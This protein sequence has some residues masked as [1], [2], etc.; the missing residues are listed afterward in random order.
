M[1]ETELA[2]I[3]S[4]L[5]IVLP[6]E[7]RQFMLP[8][9]IPA[10]AGNT[11]SELWD[12]ANALIELNLELRKGESLTRPWPTHTFA[13]GRDDGGSVSAFDLRTSGSTVYWA[14]RGHLEDEGN[15]GSGELFKEWVSEVIESLNVR[16]V[17]YGVSPD[18][19]PK[20]RQQIEATTNAAHSRAFGRFLGCMI[21]V[22]AIFWGAVKWLAFALR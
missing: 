6:S 22:A 18:S 20:E 2:Q 8:F 17:E 4:E 15:R 12:D 10:F 19:S 16:L 21:V 3:E 11:E 9:P 14:D 13:I 1:T 7:Y 5:G